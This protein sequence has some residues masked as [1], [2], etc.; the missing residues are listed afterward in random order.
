MKSRCK[1]ILLALSVM[2][3]AACGSLKKSPEQKRAEAERVAELVKQKLDARKYKINIDYMMPRRG[4][5]KSL[6]GSYSITVDGNKLNSYLPYY[7]T[8]Y[9]VPYGGGKGLIF[10]DDIVAYA[11]DAGKTD[12]RIVEFVCDNGEDIITYTLTVFDSG[13]ADVHVHCR[14]R[15]DISYRGALDTDYS[16]G[17]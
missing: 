11:E 9:S 6:T 14:N 4:S 16:P 15:D 3:V 8:A 10:E 7:G 13:T 17:E 5:G 12:R 1:I 2:L